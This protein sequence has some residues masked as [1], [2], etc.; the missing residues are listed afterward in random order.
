M[1]I[2]SI[3][4]FYRVRR[5]FPAVYMTSPFGNTTS[6][7]TTFS[8]IVPYRTAFVPEAP[9]AAI[10]HSDACAPGS[11]KHRYML[12]HNNMYIRRFSG[13]WHGPTGNQS[14][15]SRRCVLRVSRVT[16]GSTVTSK[17]SACNRSMPS[18]CVRSKHTAF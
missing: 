4:P 11:A 17:S 12:F 1:C 15:V 10:P 16:P 13:G 5:C 6:R 14:P 7:F 8:F 3:V 18:I 2:Y 9:V